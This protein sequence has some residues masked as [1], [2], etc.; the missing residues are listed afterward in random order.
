MNSLSIIVSIILFPGLITTIICDKLIVHHNKWEAF[1]YSIYSFLFGVLSYS[2][3]QIFKIIYNELIILIV[4]L[5]K[6]L[7]NRLDIWN[8]IQNEKF[9]LNLMEIAIATCIAPILAILVTNIVNKKILH[10]WTQ[11]TGLSSKYGDENL[12]SYYLNQEDI[13]FICIRDKLSEMIYVGILSAFSE[14]DMIQ[15]IT[16]LNVKVYEY[17][18]SVKLYDLDSIYLSRPQGSLSIEIYPKSE[19][20]NKNDEETNK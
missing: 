5:P 14:N 6:F 8:I 3:L 15:E 2:I 18:T 10:K 11:D 13:E 9:P 19:K 4:P 16:L 17:N 1:K 7:S 20:E 12:F